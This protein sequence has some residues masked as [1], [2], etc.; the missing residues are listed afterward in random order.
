MLYC[1]DC[2]SATPAHDFSF[3]ELCGLYDGYR[4][5][6][7]NADRISVESSY[8]DLAALVGSDPRE[9]AGRNA[10]ADAFFNKYEDVLGSGKMLDYGGSDGRFLTPSCLARYELIDIFEP[11]SVPLHPSIP[12][13][14]VR[15]VA[16]PAPASYRFV[17]C[18]HV[19]EHVGD[20]RSFVEALV[21][22]LEPGGVLYIET[23][24]EMTDAMRQDFDAKAIDTP[25]CIHEHLNKFYAG[26]VSKLISS[27]PSLELIAESQDDVSC[28]WCRFVAIRVLA[29]KL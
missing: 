4:Q 22:Y 9:L 10:A 23:P 5:E 29:R 3:E 16:E 1:H 27:L 24:Q 8:A 18:M 12:P 2:H 26:A 21:S 7:Y 20:P 17:S 28:G 15:H 14:K 11:S 13:H 19:L 25:V 6:K